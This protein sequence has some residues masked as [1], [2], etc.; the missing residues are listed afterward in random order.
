[1]QELLELEGVIIIDDQIQDFMRVFWDPSIE[2]G[3]D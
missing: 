1:M 3:W 2:L